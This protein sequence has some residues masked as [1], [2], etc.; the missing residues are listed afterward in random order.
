MFDGGRARPAIEAAVSRHAIPPRLLP[1]PK[2]HDK[3]VQHADGH[4]QND[5]NPQN[6][7]ERLAERDQDEADDGSYHSYS[8]RA[9]AAGATYWQRILTAGIP[10][11]VK[12]R[13]AMRQRGAARRDPGK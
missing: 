7:P 4:E 9:A 3:N 13:R 6:R 11:G 1:L 2:Q 12:T 10:D 8:A 5:E